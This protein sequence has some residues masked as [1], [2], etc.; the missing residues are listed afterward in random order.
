MVDQTRA[1]L[2][3]YRAGGGEVA[4]VFLE[5]VDHGIV[6]AVPGRVAEEIVKHI[7]R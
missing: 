1:V 4:E 5:G 2:E 7:T 3:R 6:L